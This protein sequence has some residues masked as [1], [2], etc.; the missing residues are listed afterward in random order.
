MP[1]C[2]NRAP[3][4]IPRRAFEVVRALLG[5]PHPDGRAMELRAALKAIYPGMLER[6]L[7]MLERE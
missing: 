5:H 2:W 7:E 3:E 1:V 4:T 6:S